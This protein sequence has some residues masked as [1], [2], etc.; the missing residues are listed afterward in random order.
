MLDSTR[1]RLEQRRQTVLVFPVRRDI[2][3]KM[4]AAL[5]VRAQYRILP[6]LL[7]VRVHLFLMAFTPHL[8]PA[9]A[10]SRPFSH[11]LLVSAVSRVAQL[12]VHLDSFSPLQ[13]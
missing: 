3:V 5:L 6:L 4:A 7:Q 11:A 2:F 8:Q 13:A 1:L 12:S 9:L 10:P